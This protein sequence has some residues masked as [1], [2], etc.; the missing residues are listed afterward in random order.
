MPASNRGPGGPRWMPS[1]LSASSAHEAA[2]RATVRRRASRRIGHAPE[3]AEAWPARFRASDALEVV[4]VLHLDG[5]GAARARDGRQQR[6]QRMRARRQ[7]Q[8][9]SDEA[10][11]GDRTAGRDSPGKEL[12]SPPSSSKPSRASRHQYAR[13]KQKC[14]NSHLQA[15][16]SL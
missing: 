13:Q 4:R 14:Y 10:R 15:S 6:D 16:I 2:P 7:Q 1:S 9:T 12:P 11:H 3:D 8:Q 5:A